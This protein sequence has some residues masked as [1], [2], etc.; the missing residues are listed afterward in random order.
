MEGGTQTTTQRTSHLANLAY[1]QQPTPHTTSLPISPPFRSSAIPYGAVQLVH[2]VLDD[3]NPSIPAVPPLLGTG[4]L[5]RYP[6]HSPAFSHSLRN[7]L[8]IFT[9]AM[10]RS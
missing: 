1:H 8:L 10:L 3:L 7:Q 6:T 5:W 2:I 4:R 9:I